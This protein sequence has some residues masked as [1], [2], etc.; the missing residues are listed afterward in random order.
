[1]PKT[2][3]A[4]KL[5]SKGLARAGKS[6]SIFSDLKNRRAIITFHSLGDLDAVGAAIALQR[7]LGKN[8][9]I[10][11][12]DRAN[13]AAR[14][15]LEYTETNTA[16]F[17][18]LKR[19]PKDAIIALDSASPH[20]MSHLAGIKPD[21]LI[22]HHARMG[23][24]MSASQEINDPAASS[25]CEMLYFLLQPTDRISCMALLLGIIS[26][27]ANFRY[28]TPR[29]FTAAA[30]LLEHCGMSYPQLLSLASAP[31]SFGERIEALRS[32]SSVSAEKIGE[33]IVAIAMA[34]SHEAHFAD[35]LVHLGADIAFVGCTGAEAKIS[36]RMRQE[37]IGRVRLDRIM[38]EVGKVLGGNGSGHELAAGASGSDVQNLKAALGICVKLSESQL[39]STEGGKIKK[40]EW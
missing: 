29:T 2:R 9:T 14:K 7:F 23:G 24:E 1:M 28:A 34:K 26:D 3:P 6:A 19:T 15:L 30:S 21:I 32:C 39:L 33:H 31:E 12:P 18:E 10:A 25:T 13:S 22:D 40:I 17:S 36:A 35:M 16:I 4:A 20:L 37:L 11:P 8:S 5:S 27:S 38:F